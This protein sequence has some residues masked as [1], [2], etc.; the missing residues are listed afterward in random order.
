MELDVFHLDGFTSRCTTCRLEHNFIVETKSKLRHA[1]QVALH[2]DRAK[3]FGPN[4][5]P[6]C[7]DL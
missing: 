4:D 1:R 5:V 7:I 3:D 6:V 2:L